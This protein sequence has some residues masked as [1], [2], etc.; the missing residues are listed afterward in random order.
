LVGR[1]IMKKIFEEEIAKEMKW[2]G[3]A[4]IVFIFVFLFTILVVSNAIIS[5]I[6]ILEFINK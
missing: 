2:V 5:D 6:K 3:I 1:K 4:I